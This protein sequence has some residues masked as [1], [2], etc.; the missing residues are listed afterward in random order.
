[1]VLH[2]TIHEALVKEAMATGV[3]ATMEHFDYIERQ[4]SHD[5]N[6][7]I[8]RYKERSKRFG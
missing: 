5:R 1:M 3:E 2:S 4:F 7:V 6:Y 8:H